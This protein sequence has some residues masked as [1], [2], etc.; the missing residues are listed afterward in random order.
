MQA[1]LRVHDTPV[2]VLGG[3]GGWIVQLVPFQPSPRG[4]CTTWELPTVPTASQLV[5]VAQET[6]ESA[7]T[8][9]AAIS[10]AHE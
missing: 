1:V 10:D 3:G 6:L 8:L 5:A 4:P 7:A 9:Q 2:S